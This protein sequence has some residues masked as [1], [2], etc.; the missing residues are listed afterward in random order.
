MK[1]WHIF[2]I[3]GIAWAWKWT[4]VDN[5]FKEMW[6][7]FN[8]IKSCKT[9]EPRPWEILWKDY[10]KLSFDEFK[11]WVENG[12]FI[13]H[14]LI[15]N[16]DYY[17]TRLEDFENA[18]NSWKFY[19]KELDMKWVALINETRPELKQYY[20][21]IFIDLP[22]E[23]LKERMI[24]RGDDVS[25]KDY[26]NRLNSAKIERSM[27]DIADYIIDWEKSK[28]EVFSEFKAIFSKYK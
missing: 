25:W 8:F 24:M 10:T 14:I 15:H 1:K 12:D 27:K 9:R 11:K 26:E 6:D 22:E 20:T 17:W 2:I 19:I 3:S 16:Q 18:I 7:E 5:I 23:K 28:E 4:L 13:E 21:H